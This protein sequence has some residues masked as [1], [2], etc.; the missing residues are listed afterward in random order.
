VVLDGEFSAADANA[1]EI[2]EI[3]IGES[4]DIQI[5]RRAFFSLIARALSEW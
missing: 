3:A 4:L 2:I 5:N 1:D